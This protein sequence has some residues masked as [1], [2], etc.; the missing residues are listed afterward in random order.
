VTETQSATIEDASSVTRN[1]EAALRRRS[2]PDA[3]PNAKT[4][5]SQRRDPAFS[6]DVVCRHSSQ[7]GSS[8]VCSLLPQKG[9]IDRTPGASPRPGGT[10]RNGA[11]EPLAVSSSERFKPRRANP[12]RSPNPPRRKSTRR[13]LPAPPFRH[14]RDEG[15]MLPER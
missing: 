3:P 13:D 8:V 2:I 15:S 5:E 9:Q 4:R 1:C 11:R 6:A 12:Y 14:P 7:Q 10:T